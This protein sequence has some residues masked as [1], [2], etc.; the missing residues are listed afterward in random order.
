MVLTELKEDLSGWREITNAVTQRCA[1]ELIL[2]NVFIKKK[3]NSMLMTSDYNMASEG[4]I[5]TK[6][7]LNGL[8][9]K[10]HPKLSHELGD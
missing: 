7:N 2:F 1:L 8:Q 5:N 10:K 3:V 6:E 4:T 9:K